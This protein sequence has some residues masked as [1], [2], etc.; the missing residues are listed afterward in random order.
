MTPTTELDAIIERSLR[1]FYQDI[2]SD[3]CGRENEMINL[4]AWGRLTKEV[5]SES[6]LHDLTQ[7]GIEVAVRQ[8]PL[9]RFPGIV[10]TVRKDLVIWPTAGMTLWKE[11]V[12]HNEPLAVMEWK[13]NHRFN[14]AAHP[15]NRR[16]H[17]GDIQW[18]RD[19][20]LLS[21]MAMFTGYAVLVEHTRVPRELHCVKVHAGVDEPFLTEPTHT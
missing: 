19:A 17:K 4:Y 7:I 12:P 21:G 18:L 8:K 13:V 14:R 2:C 10:R 9:A 20:F 15:L 6:L 3:W 1:S 16:L 11:N 5:R